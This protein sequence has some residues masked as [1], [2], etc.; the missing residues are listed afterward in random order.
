MPMID[1]APLAEQLAKIQKAREVW[2]TLVDKTHARYDGFDNLPDD[3][4][5]DM[6][7]AEERYIDTLKE[8]EREVRKAVTG[9]A[10]TVTRNQ[11]P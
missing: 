4:R 7:G 10:P 5:A 6:S 1:A 3:V 9:E 11:S 8:L 2:I